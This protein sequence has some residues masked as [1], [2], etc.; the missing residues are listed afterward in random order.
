MA[1]QEQFSF[2]GENRSLY[3]DYFLKE[4]LS[5]LDEWDKDISAPFQ[6]ALKLYQNK[7]SVL[8][9]MNEAQTE[10]EFIQPLLEQV[11]GFAYDV[12]KAE[13]KQGRTNIPDYILFPNQESL[14]KAQENRDH[15]RYYNDSLALSDAK[16]WE[17]PLDSKV[18][19]EKDRYTNANPSF[20]IVNYLT[21]TGL[22]WGILTNGRHWR[23]YSTKA[24]S[25]IDSYFEVDLKRILEEENEQQFRYFYHFFCRDSYQ[26]DPQTGQSFIERVFEG[27]IDYGTQL[28]KRLKNLIFEDVFLVLSKGFVHY[29]SEES[30]V[31]NETEESLQI[32]YQGTLRLLYRLLF[33]LHAESRSLLPLDNRGYFQ[34]SLM[35][36]KKDLA[37]R[38]DQDLPQ[39]SRSFDVWNDLDS[40]FHII[41]KGDPDLNVPRYNGGLF[42]QDHPNNQFLT[43]HKIADKFLVPALEMLTRETEVN[44][45]GNKSFIDYK[46]LNVEQLGSIYEGLLEFHLRRADEPLAVVKEN[47]K[48]LFKSLDEVEHPKTILDEGDLYLEN[49]KGERKATGSY[50]T[51]HYIVEYIVEHTLGPVFEERKAT[52]EELMQQWVPKYDEFQKLDKKISEGDRSEET[53]NRRKELNLEIETLGKQASETLLSIKVCDPAMGSGHFLK[54]ATD[55]LAEMIITLLAEYPENPVS[56]LLEKVR[57]Q[58]LES[59]TEQDISI[60]ADEHLKDTNLIKRMVMKRSIYGVD[61]NPMA[62]ELAKLSLWLD[63]FTVGA[64]LSFLDHHLKVGN[65]LIGTTVGEIR[66]RL[67][68]GQSHMFG[69]PFS[70]LLKATELMREVSVKTDATYSEVEQSIERY[71]DFEEAVKPYKQVLDIWLSRHFDNERAGDFLVAFSDQIT[72]LL[73]GE[74]VNLGDKQQAFIGKAEALEQQKHFFHWELEFP[75]VF[76]DLKQSRWLVNPGFDVVIGNPPYDILIKSERGDDIINYVNKHFVTAEY[77]PNYYVLFSEVALNISKNEGWAAFIV[78]NMWLTNEKYSKMRKYLTES[79]KI[80]ELLDL[81]FSVF[82]EIIPTMIYVVKKVDNISESDKI[83]LAVIKDESKN[84][85]P[86]IRER[87]SQIELADKVKVGF[88]DYLT[89]QA[90]IINRNSCVRLETKYII[91]RGIETK[92]NS[93]YLS[94]EKRNEKDKPVLD[95]TDVKNYFVKWSGLYVRFIPEELKS[96][97]DESYYK[98]P[99]K[100]LLRRTGDKLIAGIDHNQFFATKNLYL[101]IPKDNYTSEFLCGILNSRL[102]N[103]ERLRITQD[104][105]QAFAQLKGSEV[106]RLP[107]PNFAINNKEIEEKK[108]QS[109]WSNLIE[110]RDVLEFKNTRKEYLVALCETAVEKQYGFNEKRLKNEGALDTFKF[111]NKGVSFRP[112]KNVFSESIK[113]GQQNTNKIDIGTVHHDIEALH[114]RPDN[115][116]WLLSADL[117]HRDPE[118]DWA[119]W[120]KEDGNIVRTTHDIFRF[121]LSDKEARYWQQCFEVLDEFENSSKFPG[122]KTRTTYEKLMKSKVPVFDESASIEPLIELREELEVVKQKIEKT[123]WLIDQV[124]YQLYGLSEEEIE[125]V[126]ASAT[127]G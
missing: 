79:S 92:D 39:S 28:E 55:K 7:K 77:N 114:L 19:A 35:K 115:K 108:L 31:D 125:I 45:S 112:F 61:L 93:I 8:P 46:S 122:G 4:R 127:N 67:E 117:K 104:K 90:P 58:I 51:P 78:P 41:D 18:V 118:S 29:R 109:D 70:G 98:V 56:N 102:M 11:L 44:E 123:D 64:P 15:D 37:D 80:S 47:S 36:L 107:I 63:S 57:G 27:S 23:L 83:R 10:N 73:K 1:D 84:V 62:V 121:K 74:K 52:F 95:A 124:V 2:F 24:R 82:S 38:I 14:T 30:G 69:G 85:I 103:W 126:E 89:D 66:E 65:S 5:T 9:G 40:L 16:Y 68:T 101:L 72:N 96:N 116:Q 6:K 88:N 32:I 48:E 20:Q 13:K 26:T 3:S 75:E 33:L 34:Y 105:G 50:Y 99:S 87:I 86:K 111:I 119:D 21:V 94:T 97:A 60:D 110:G 43:E 25:R 71:H 76:V 49:D 91:Y 81:K 59:L 12:Q 22:E 113:Y 100:V 42:R 17:R 106:A 120:A 54:E 53:H